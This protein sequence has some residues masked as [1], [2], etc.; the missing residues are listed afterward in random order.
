MLPSAGS[1]SFDDPEWIFEASP[2]GHRAIA[3]IDGDRVHLHSRA[4]LSYDR[5]FPEIAEALRS[6]PNQM[7]LD[8]EIVVAPARKG[9]RAAGAMFV[10]QDLL[11]LN[12]E[13]LRDR[14]LLERKQRLNKLKIF[15]ARVIA[16]EF[17]V[18]RGASFAAKA[19]KQGHASVIAKHG[20]SLYRSGV[21]REWLKVPAAAAAPRTRPPS[22][23]QPLVAKPAT[24]TPRSSRK[25]IEPAVPSARSARSPQVAQP[26]VPWTPSPSRTPQRATSGPS[27]RPTPSSSPSTATTGP[28]GPVL[29]NLNKI[30]WPDEGL[31]KG[32]LIA[33]YRAMAPYL[34]PHLRGRPESLNRHPSG[35]TGPNF[36]QKDLT[37]Y[38]PRWVKTERVYSESSAKT[39]HYALCEDEATLLYLANLGCIELNPWLSRVGSLDR[40]DAVVIDLDPDDN[41]FAEVIQVAKETERVLHAIGAPAC[42][43]TSGATGLHICIPT[44]GRY[45]FDEARAFAEAVC[46]RVHAACPRNTSLERNPARRR[47]KIYLDFM[48]NR[49]GQTLAAPYCVR[50]RPG[51]PVS[52]PLKWSEL[53]RGLRPEQ[54]TLH[55][56]PA[57]VAR[58]GDLWA[59]MLGKGADLKAC[60]RKLLKLG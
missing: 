47:S 45:D 8:G 19:A 2:G 50:P 58:V 4:L 18:G 25:V 23:G 55:N 7:V 36:F 13:N 29:T 6:P 11:Y 24:A 53:K 43:K 41:D 51:A 28:R 14:P 21:S 39:I 3:V 26:A 1:S 37:G 35:I 38:V 22:A 49:R 33:Y 48:Q 40:P 56:M 57:R 15:N 27:S 52:A 42:L 46:R 34:L 10:V 59:P 9:A 54:F 12:G 31:T 5:K 16:G 30:Y 20:A 44:A 17:V 60:L 32:D